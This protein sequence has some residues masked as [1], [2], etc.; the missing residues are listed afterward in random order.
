MASSAELDDIDF[1]DSPSW[2]PA[3]HDRL[4]WLRENDP[5]SWSPATNA[6][7]VT[8]F[9]DVS[10]ISRNQALFTSGRGV[11]RS[12]SGVRIGL[13]DEPEPRHGE[14][15]RLIARGFTPRMVAKLEEV[16]QRLT[17]EYVDAVADKG[18]CDFVK[19]IS[20]P[21]PLLMIAEM[22]GI[23]SADRE[24]F[25]HWSDALIAADGNYDR[26]EIMEQ[27]VL[28]FAEYSE[29]VTEIIEDRKANPQDDLVSI[30]VG[31]SEA[32]LLF[33]DA[34]FHNEQGPAGESLD[35]LPTGELIMF[36]VLLLV[37]G[38]E[39]T[40]NGISGGMQLL[41]EN[42]GQCQ[43]LVDDPELIPSAVEEMLRL[44]SPVH[45]FTRTVT[46]DTE[47]RGVPMKEGDDV[48]I[49]YPSANRDADRYD[50]PDEFRA[51]RNP[52]HLAFGIGPHFCLGASL[53][54]M[55]MRVVF[56]TVL[57]RMADLAYADPDRGAVIEPS[58]LVRNCTEMQITYTAR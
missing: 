33:E 35:E 15:R 46:E 8:K 23:R 26:P 6:F 50:D 11:R 4:R 38:N 31:A 28:A 18:A 10:A 37:A 54:R 57:R 3:M 1:M 44:V 25:H 53:A 22:I 19:E 43:R 45:S 34:D 47:V 41:I 49:L 48:L 21:L 2:G 42:P 39:T 56:S 12:T 20:V 58:A 32:G 17:D 29:Y 14:L 51:D 55:E 52:Q 30:L 9:E 27:S 7:V 24:R 40:R 13:I 36:L 5:V 16:F